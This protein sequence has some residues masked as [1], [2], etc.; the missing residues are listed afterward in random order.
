M[1]FLL[2]LLV[3]FCL[4]NDTFSQYFISGQVVSEN[5][6]LPLSGASV[7]INGSTIGTVTN[8]SGMFTLPN[9]SNGFYDVIASYV[10]YEAVVYRA[11]ISSKNLQIIFKLTKKPSE[12]R[13]VVVLSKD[14]RAKWLAIFRQ[15]F[16]GITEAARK[17][18]ITNEEEILFEDGNSRDSIKAFSLVPLEIVNK[19]LG[20]KIYFELVGFYYSA[21]Q[22]RTY[23]YGYSRFEELSDKEQVPA[24][25]LKNREL[26]YL[27]STLHF[28]HSLIDGKSKEEGFSTL[29]I[30]MVE[31]GDS[32][33]LKAKP[34]A[35]FG[36]TGAKVTIGGAAIPSKM[37]AGFAIEPN[38]FFAR[39]TSLSSNVYKLDWKEQLRVTYKKDP[40][41]KKYL[42]KTVFLQGSLPLGVYSDID[43]LEAP[44][45]MD[46]NGSLYNP[47]AV[48]MRGFWSYEKLANML[49]LDYRPKNLVGKK[50]L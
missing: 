39:D 9:V 5:G 22:G 34:P 36:N 33:T 31:V 44:V 32:N 23:F 17:C 47:L 20:Y 7:Y 45:Y 38:D 48:Q 40:Y 4:V 43:M 35:V 19:E 15:N 6:E 12:L 30:R 46:G 10:G 11:N 49:P 41:T 3:S 13:S 24:R 1:K 27:G 8:T 29:N 42:S 50:G 37:R 28:Y 16:L 2:V 18:K 26:Y 21:S 25:Y 14:A